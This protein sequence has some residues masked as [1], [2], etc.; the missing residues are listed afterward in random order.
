MVHQAL[1]PITYRRTSY[2]PASTRVT[3]Y[4]FART[5]EVY[6]IRYTCGVASIGS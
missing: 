2:M 5:R 3:S 1:V 6:R 4:R